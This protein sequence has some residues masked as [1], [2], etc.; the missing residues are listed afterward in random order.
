MN[1][2]LPIVILLL[3]PFIAPAQELTTQNKNNTSAKNC[4]SLQTGMYYYTV[5]KRQNGG[6]FNYLGANYNRLLNKR[7][8]IYTQV[9]YQFGEND[10]SNDY[11]ENWKVFDYYLYNKDRYSVRTSGKNYSF[12]DLGVQ[13]S[14]Y[15][16]KD[17][18]FSANLGVSAA[19]GIRIYMQYVYDTAYYNG[20]LYPYSH[21][22]EKLKRETIFG[23]TVGLTANYAFMDDRFTVGSS[24][25]ARRYFAQYFPFQ[26]NFG[27]HI[28][29]LF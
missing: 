3:L 25:T 20:I 15:K 22:I 9:M 5:V 6:P 4:F 2:I 1:K 19:E 29:V 10:A 27:V 24:I 17:V 26:L 11:E 7:L 14:F 21:S 28:G 18:S 8:S 16:Y 13:Y 23:G 12:W